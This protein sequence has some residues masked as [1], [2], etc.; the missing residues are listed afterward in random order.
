MYFA[1]SIHDI[2]LRDKRDGK[3]CLY[4]MFYKKKLLNKIRIGGLNKDGLR[5][6]ILS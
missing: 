5:Y 1:V 3:I 6:I 2:I 4:S